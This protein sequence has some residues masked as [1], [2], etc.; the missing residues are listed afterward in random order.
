MPVMEIGVVRVPMDEWLMPVPMT[1]G[2]ADRD[3]RPMR[4]LMMLVMGMP[5]LMLHRF[6]P[7][8][9]LVAFRQVQPE[10]N[11]H[12]TPRRQQPNR[13]R[14]IEQR[15]REQR[16][17]EGSQRKI[18]SGACRPEMAQAQH[19]QGET[20]PI[21]EKADHSCRQYSACARQYS[22][23]RHGERQIDCSRNQPLKR[24]FPQKPVVA[25]A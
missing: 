23:L 2:L 3:V 13:H 1:V 10:A 24:Q 4:V 12:Q 21:T 5:V 17:N 25:R 6:V 11:R 8:L 22:A 18:G 7:M 15:Q 9:M 16:A 20:D 14:L 19:E